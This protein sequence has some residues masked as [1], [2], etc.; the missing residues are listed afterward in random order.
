M[1]KRVP[2]KDGI[3][4]HDLYETYPD[5]D[6]DPDREQALLLK[7][8]IVIMQHPFY[9][10]SC[11]AILKQWQDLV[12]EHGFAYGRAGTALSG[13]AMLSAVTAGGSETAYGPEGLNRH[14]IAEFLRP[15]EATAR[16]CR[17]RWQPPFVVH[18]THLLE[19]ADLSRHAEAYRARLEALRD[20]P[21]A[22]Q[23][24]HAREA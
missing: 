17:M 11:P 15:F 23:A 19:A 16:L 5:Y 9:W 6:I 24:L 14:A 1:I 4:L 7:H 18:G 20:A 2:R 12:L 10:Y 8:D 3:T 13:K 22:A 21:A